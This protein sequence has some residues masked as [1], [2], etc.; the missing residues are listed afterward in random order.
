[1]SPAASPAASRPPAVA[2]LR[3]TPYA[4]RQWRPLSAVA[5]LSLVNIGI[6][7]LKPWPAKLIIDQVIGGAPWPTAADSWGVAARSP[8]WLL[9]W[10]AVA[11]VALF[12]AG[13]VVRLLDSHFRTTASAGMTLD[14]GAR[15]F[16][17]VQRL[18]VQ[19]HS[20]RS[21]GDLIRRI[22]TDA[23]FPAEA[24]LWVW[25]TILTSSLTLAGMFVVMWAF[26]PVLSGMSLLAIPP[27]L[28]A[29]RRYSGPMGLRSYEQQVY[30]GALLSHVEQTLSALPVV[31][32]FVREPRGDVR[33]RRLSARTVAAYLRTADAQLRYKLSTTAATALVTALII[34]VGGHHVLEG[35]LSI[36]AIVVFLSYLGSLYAPLESLAYVGQGLASTAAHRRRVSEVLLDDDVVD[37]ASDRPSTRSTGQSEGIRLDDVVFEYADGNRV[38]DHVTL[39]VRR[40]EVVALVGDSGAGKTT[41]LLIMARLL[42]PTGGRVLVDGVDA[43]ACDPGWLRSRVAVVFQEPFLLPWTIAENI[44]CGQ[45]LDQS[46]LAWAASAA[47]A[48]SFIGRL[49][50]GYET[51]LGERGAT[52]S[53]GERQRIAIARALYAHATVLLLDEPTS[54]L[55]VETEQALMSSILASKES[56]ATLVVAHRLTTVQRADRIVVLD[57]G[58]VIESGTHEHLLA[59]GGRYAQLTSLL[60]RDG[61]S[62][63]SP[64][65]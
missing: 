53:G 3:V 61:F 52:L 8:E 26:D 44:V 5:L 25:L 37:R 11:S 36:G 65:V 56:R 62:G 47:H 14:A 15:L 39:D 51:R 20:R 21:T 40:G 54:A 46:R 9:S 38:L 10:L 28:L 27:L 1:M 63:P 64:A 34:V 45:P 57:K 22:V 19:F 7:I 48:D 42:I 2:A 23:S 33:F 4:R 6:D 32:S 16:D 35:R 41:A 58:R 43:A 55:D 49:S 59:Q 30:E 12:M 13:Q 29:A 60:A 17:H 18:S 24:V 31:Q 50:A